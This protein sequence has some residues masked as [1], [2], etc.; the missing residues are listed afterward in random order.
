MP[1]KT[2]RYKN[3]K[4]P[5]ELVVEAYNVFKGQL[6]EENK[7]SYSTTF[8]IKINDSESW[9]FDSQEEFFSEFRK[10]IKSADFKHQHKSNNKGTAIFHFSFSKFFS[11]FVI[12]I[13]LPER[14]QIEKVF[15]IFESS[16][17]KYCIPEVE[18]IKNIESNVKIFIGHGRNTQW[19]ALKEH[20]QDKHGFNVI[21]YETGARAGYT[22]TEIL[23]EM[24]SKASFALLVLTAEDQSA[25]GQFHARENVIHETGLFQGKLGFKKAIVLL[26]DGCNEFSNISGVQQI[27]FPKNSIAQTFGDVLATV[28][29]EYDLLKKISS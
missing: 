8:N 6:A 10:D 25:D 23:E 15:E 2:I 7:I 9:Q 29:R 17:S 1:S 24:S 4:F 13:E 22:I 14:H 28:Y 20:L 26:E 19:K 12:W 11:E 16:Y 3:V 18:L 27:R 5:P 21:C